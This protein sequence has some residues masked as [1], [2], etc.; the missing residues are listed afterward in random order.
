MNCQTLKKSGC[1]IRSCVRTRLKKFFDAVE[2]LQVH[3]HSMIVRCLPQLSETSI[4]SG[5]V[6]SNY[7]V[8]MKATK[9]TGAR[10]NI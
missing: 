9:S 1:W 8:V 6:A 5:R 4:V 3:S 7:L 2:N 10:Y